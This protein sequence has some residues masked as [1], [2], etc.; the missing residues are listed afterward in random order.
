MSAVDDAIEVLRQAM[1]DEGQDPGT[2]EAKLH[3]AK[4]NEVNI[5][6]NIADMMRAGATTAEVADE[7]VAGSY[8]SWTKAE[9]QAELDAQGIAYNSGDTKQDLIDRLG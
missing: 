9:L 4:P 2:V 8:A 3:S 6:G 7:E 1:L 5:V